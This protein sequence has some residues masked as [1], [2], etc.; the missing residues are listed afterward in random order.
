MEE[1]VGKPQEKKSRYSIKL[2][3]KNI[4]FALL[5]LAIGHL[6]YTYVSYLFENDRNFS[7]L[8]DLEREMSFRT[9]MGFY[10]SYYKTVVEEKPFIAGISKLMYDKTVEY[11]KEVNA[12]NRFNI[13]PEVI[14]GALY[15]YLEPWI[16]NTAYKEC[17]M[18]DRG[19]GREPVESCVGV[20]HPVFFYLEAIWV[21]AGVNVAA[22]FLHAL[23]L[24]ESFL[25]GFLAVAQYFANHAECTRVQWAP[26]ERE[27]WAGPLLL[28]QAWLL[29]VQ[30]QDRKRYAIQLQIG[31]FMLNCLCLLFW[32]FTQFIF[33]T[34]IAVFFVMEQL[35]IIDTR[36]LSIF[37]HSHYC[38]LHMAILL[39]QGNDMLK[40][41][42]YACLFLVVSAYCLFFSGLRIK[43]H[44]RFDF[45]VEAWLVLLRICIVVCA[46]V[47]LKKI[48]S[49]FLEVEEDTHVWEILYS[50]FTNY[51]S[52]H[53]LLYTCS[54]VFDFL[55]FKS[56]QNMT[57]SFLIPYVGFSIINVVYF[58]IWNTEKE[59]ETEDKEV[60][61]EGIV[62]DED[63]GIDN[64]SDMKI[65]KRS[66]LDVLDKETSLDET[67]TTD[68]CIL[69]LKNLNIDAAIFYNIAQL[70]VY[71]VMAALVMRL[72]LLFTTQL[73]LMS[74]LVFK[75]RYSKRMMK[76]VK[77]M[78]I[79][80][81]V[82]MIRCL[83]QNMGHEMSHIG[84]FSD[85]NQEELLQWIKDQAPGAFA[86][87]MPVLAAVMLATRRPI[88]AHPH[89]EHLEARQRAFAV[90]KVYGRFSP[91][92]LYQELNKLKASYLIV[93]NRYCYGRSNKGCSFSDIWD[94]AAAAALRGQPRLCHTLLAHGADHFYPLFRNPQYAVFRVHDVSVRYMPRSFDT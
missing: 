16:N 88:V 70:V 68:K 67:E 55:P 34:Q 22:L 48:I 31:I 93:E 6:H 84:E 78:L 94:S 86:G 66:D 47:Y 29:T 60:E 65:K 32:Q 33:L 1:S 80:G 76:Y 30:L 3:V 92:E 7:Y 23:E 82:P 46:S 56:I 58:W 13:H 50:K 44:N 10:Y 90:Y 85:Y 79:L 12:F 28:L 42:L 41:S 77:L 14:V 64:S 91:H 49:D 45:L 89:Y 2:I 61:K 75:K 26:N 8:S 69:F 4:L 19:V 36:H 21:F 37:L 72:K 62:D 57:Y 9:E 5:V 40:S 63:S 74:S 83:V 11:P 24:S 27:N 38:G 73:C 51:K 54:E 53:T 20:G 25:G 18:V 52:F 71:G 43:V 35:R 15:R 39:L 81:A 87:S 17:H 59:T